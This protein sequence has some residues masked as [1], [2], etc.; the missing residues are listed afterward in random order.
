MS[1]NPWLRN[2]G[3]P[4]VPAL[5]LD[6]LVVA[7]VLRTIWRA[8]VGDVGVMRRLARPKCHSRRATESGGAKVAFERRALVDEMFLDIRHVIQRLHME[9]LIVRQNED[10]IWSRPW[11]HWLRKRTNG[12][13][14]SRFEVHNSIGQ[15]SAEQS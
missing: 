2:L 1:F 3:Y 9:V 7:Q 12:N 6:D 14:A 8:H 11:L 4:P 13:L 10:D 15:R 5:G